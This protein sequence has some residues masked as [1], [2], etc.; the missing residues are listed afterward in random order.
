M[1]WRILSPTAG[2]GLSAMFERRN[3]VRS[4][5]WDFIGRTISSAVARSSCPLGLVAESG[6]LGR[7]HRTSVESVGKTQ[8]NEG[9]G[10][11]PSTKARQDERRKAVQSIRLRVND[12]GNRDGAGRHLSYFSGSPLPPNRSSTAPSLRISSPY[13]AQSPARCAASAA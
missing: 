7:P 8:F 13:L 10:W 3:S 5:C 2:S 9:Q 11:M 12:F 4:N 1:R 6:G